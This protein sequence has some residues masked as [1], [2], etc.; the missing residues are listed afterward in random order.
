MTPA[1]ATMVRVETGISTA[2]NAIVPT[3]IIWAIGVPPPL[4]LFGTNDGIVRGVIL[5]TGVATL[6]MTLVVTLLVRGRVRKRRVAP[7]PVAALP[8]LA[9][10]LPRAL[11][12]RAPVLALA[13]AAIL[14]P[15]WLAVV[16]VLDLLP[17]TR[18][19]LALF[20]VALGTSVGLAMTPWVVLRA[21]AD[22]VT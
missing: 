18:T 1:H 13:A 20:N 10:G 6:L 21:F 8:P 11:A 4:T 2:I 5:G 16:V 15:L 17:M 22:P 7:L 14:A 12:L 3:A 9:R 19:G